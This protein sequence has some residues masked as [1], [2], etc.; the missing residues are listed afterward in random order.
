[1]RNRRAVVYDDDR[2]VLAV[3]RMFFSLRGYDVMTFEDTVICPIRENSSDCSSPGTCAD[4]IIADFMMPE[5]TGMELF[6]AQTERGCKLEAKNKAIMSEYDINSRDL[7]KIRDLGHAFFRRP[8]DFTELSSWLAVRE[9]QMDLLQPLAISRKERCYESAKTVL[10]TV[11]SHI[12]EPNR[13][14]PQ[15]ERLGHV[16]ESRITSSKR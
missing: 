9:L 15:C 12:E 11:A 16:H 3:L 14:R 8:F 5:M 1:M 7:Q 2:A 4:I 10:Y 6:K 13:H